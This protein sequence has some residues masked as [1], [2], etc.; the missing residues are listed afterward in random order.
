[1][2]FL[3]LLGLLTVLFLTLTDGIPSAQAQGDRGV[4]NV[5]S[6][7]HY[8]HMEPVF[9]RFM[10]ETGIEVRF[11][12][13]KDAELR[14]R[15][16]AEGRFTLADVYIGVDAG[17]LWLAAQE[18]ILQ[19]IQSE[20]IFRSIPEQFRDPEGYWTALA[21]RIRTIVHH[22]D[23]VSPAELSTYEALAD[24]KW[25][26]RLCLRPATKVYTQSL[27]ASLIAA[28]GVEKAEEIV[29]GWVENTPRENFI[30][31]DTRIA[32]TIAS[33]GC[34]VGIINHYYLARLLN[35]D[36][37]S[38]VKLFWANQGEGERGVHANISGAGVV[39]YARNVEN[40]I[41]LL[42][43]LSRETG[44]RLFADG[45]FEYPANPRVEPHPLVAGFGVPQIDPIPVWRYGEL[46]AEAIELMNRVGYP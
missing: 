9:Q 5:Y 33:G 27:V 11:T 36:P 24:P 45:N 40:A 43:W 13:G 34:D 10:E 7:R 28:H 14:E 15:I 19:P 35:E 17:N 16:K 3:P 4:V 30:D 18:G 29:R 32:Q 25:R 21:L 38:P 26:G 1:M 44:Q 37:D 20:V 12:F 39:K 22:P 46:Q 8:G 31:S 41:A 23:R 6:A 2:A 42:E